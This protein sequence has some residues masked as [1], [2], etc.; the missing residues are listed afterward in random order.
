[1]SHSK[2][3]TKLLRLTTI[4]LPT[5]PL[6]LPQPRVSE[7]CIVLTRNLGKYSTAT[8]YGDAPGFIGFW[9]VLRTYA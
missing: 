7:R 9:P 6:I 1:M 2:S 4:P 8:S 3:L 5:T